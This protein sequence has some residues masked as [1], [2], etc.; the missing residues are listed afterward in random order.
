[1]KLELLNFI[2][3]IYELKLEIEELKDFGAKKITI[4][5]DL[6]LHTIFDDDIKERIVKR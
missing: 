4:L 6:N 3:K 1:M 2:N 5:K